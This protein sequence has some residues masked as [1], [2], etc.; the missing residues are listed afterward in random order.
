MVTSQ[1]FFHQNGIEAWLSEGYFAR[2]ETFCPRYGWLKKGFD[3][4]LKNSHIF[5]EPDA[6]EQLGVGKNMVRAIRFWCMAFHIIGPAGTSSQRRLGGSM[7][8]NPLGNALLSDEGWDPFLEDPASLWLLHWKLFT[9][10]IS[11]IAWSLTINLNLSHPF[12]LRGLSETLIERKNRFPIL[13]RYSDS[14][15][16]KDASCFIRMYASSGREDSE[17]I[18]CPFTDLKLLSTDERNTY[19]FR[20]D[21]KPTLPDMIFLAAC[22]DYAFHTQPNLRSISLNKLTYEFNC[23]GSVFKL[24]ETDIGHRLEKASRAMDGVSFTESHGTRQLQFENEPESLFWQALSK[25]Y[26]SDRQAANDSI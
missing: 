22:F 12:T 1:T 23:P 11:A 8:S 10:P 18:E 4:V 5:D 3:G 17:E 14:S 20:M 15:I 24:S 13:R 21:E 2:H 9:P 25:Y 6:I 26:G 16:Y 7:Q 19:Q